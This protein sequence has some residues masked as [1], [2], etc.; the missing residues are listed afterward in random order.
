[1]HG[2]VA[3][4]AVQC[5]LENAGCFCGEDDMLW[6]QFGTPTE[7]AL[8]TFQVRAEQHCSY[9]HIMWN[10]VEYPSSNCH[11]DRKRAACLCLLHGCRR[12][13]FNASRHKIDCRMCWQKPTIACIAS[14]N[15]PSVH[16]AAGHAGA[17]RDRGVGRDGMARAAETYSFAHH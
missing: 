1:M 5:A 17:A 3:A 12:E 8:R 2:P 14:R 15:R 11:A 9:E 13:C 10:L 7:S 16:W 4:S 6:W